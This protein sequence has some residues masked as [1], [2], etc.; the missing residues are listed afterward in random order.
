[1]PLNPEYIRI[2]NKYFGY[3]KI[4]PEKEKR[5]F[6][7]RLKAFMYSKEFIG[8]GGLKITAEMRVLLSASAIQ[9]TFGLP[10]IYLANF[11]KILI[12]P[13]TYYSTISQ[14]YHHG[15]VNPRAGIIVI[16]WMKFIEGYTDQT[17]SLN[18]GLH[19]MAHAIHFED[20]IANEEYGFLDS[21]S[22][23]TLHKIFLR[24]QAGI[25]NGIQTYIRPYGATNEYEFFA[26]SIEHFFEDPV[27]LRK[28]VPDLYETL[29]IL[30][31]QDPIRL[32]NP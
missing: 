9:L 20:R 11:R 19:E 14:Q 32:V 16:S 2:L 22:L 18:V 5:E 17:D 30:L 29:K 3:Y 27:G 13:D 4:L 8:R 21:R 23:D 28:N 10:M 6:E 15:E 24:E 31:N 7:S 25:N 1:M 26:V 12:Y